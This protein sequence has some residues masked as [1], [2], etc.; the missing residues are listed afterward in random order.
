[1]LSHRSPAG[2]EGFPGTVDARVTYTMTDR[3][4]LVVDYQATTDAPTHVNLTQHTYWNL[5][6]HG[7]AGTLP[8]ILDHEVT[9][10]ASRFTPVDAELIPT[11]ELRAVR[12][13]PFDFTTPRRIGERI[14]S[15]DEQLRLGQGYDHNF[16]LDRSG[17]GGDLVFA[18]RVHHAPTGRVL[19]VLTT[20][21]GIQLYTGNFL[22]GEA[23][24]GG[25][26]YARRT[27]LALETQHFPDSPNKPAF[28]STVLRPGETYASRTVFAFSVGNAS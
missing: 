28:P 20:E 25:S 19:E 22:R 27:G 21:P 24:K 17:G 6:G 12:G 8:E 15:D 26:V 4:Q 7:A 5:A 2:I 9:I 3:D 16:V 11:G 14:E 1:M 23:G 18:A 10:A 13:T